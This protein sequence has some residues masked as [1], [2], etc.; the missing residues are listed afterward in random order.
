MIRRLFARAVRAFTKRLR[1]QRYHN[2]RR[3]LRS[4]SPNVELTVWTPYDFQVTVN[5]SEYLDAGIFYF[6]EYD[7][8]MT[9]FCLAFLRAGDNAL[10]IGAGHGWFSLLLG[11]IVGPAG[12]VD[13]FE[14]QVQSAHR[15]QRDLDS[16]KYTWVKLHP[17]A[18]ADQNGTA[19]F[20]PPK[21]VSSQQT[22]NDGIGHLTSKSNGAVEVKVV[23]IDGFLPTNCDIQ[24]VK[25]DVEGAETA[26]LRGASQ[27]FNRARP[28]I[29]TEYNE[30]A[31]VRQG[32]S[33]AELD[34]LLNEMGYDR[35]IFRGSWQPFD[36]SSYLE[37]PEPCVNVYCFHREGRNPFRMGP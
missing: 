28:I 32:S 10:D 36:M 7:R 20:L 33:T 29:A 15:I 34:S 37:H 5:P 21:S 4:V 22:S 1:P 3:V 30:L 13:S 17:V 18:V 8:E 19:Y 35:Y 6:D 16:N 31:L 24:L 9:D 2:L 23:R 11:K 14:A 26:T 27:L 12:R 25:L